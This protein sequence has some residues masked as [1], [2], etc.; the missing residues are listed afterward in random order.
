MTC[1]SPSHSVLSPS[2][3]ESGEAALRRLLASRAIG[4][5]SLTSDDPAPESLSASQSS[6]VARPQDASN[7]PNLVSLLSSWARSYLGTCGQR[8]LR[9]VSGLL[10]RKPVGRYVGPVFQAAGF[11]R[12]LV[13][14]GSFGF[15]EDAVKLVGLFVVAKRADAQ[16]F[17]I[18]ARASNLHF[19]RL[20]SGTLLT[21]EG[22]CHVEFQGESSADFRNA[23]HQMRIPGCVLSRI[24]SWLHRKNGQPKTSGSRVFDTFCPNNISLGILL[25]GVF[26]SRRHGP[27]HAL[28]KY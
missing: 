4:R 3:T 6:R 25:G 7:A 27:L 1:T 19:L 15:V 21:G 14:A 11:V 18:D 22:L 10:T 12:D 8:M 20:P 9:P 28:G 2:V 23:F 26:L 16:R 5:H 13:K 17:I 24:R